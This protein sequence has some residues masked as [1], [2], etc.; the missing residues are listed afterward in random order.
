M[1]TKFKFPQFRLFF[2]QIVGSDMSCVYFQVP[3]IDS[4]ATEGQKPAQIE[5]KIEFR[6]VAF[7]YPSCPDAQ[8]SHTVN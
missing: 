3:P 2:T 8:V 1:E 4:S 7:Q 5:G 6:D